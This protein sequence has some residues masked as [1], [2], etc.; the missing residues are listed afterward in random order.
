MAKEKKDVDSLSV[1]VSEPKGGENFGNYFRGE[2]EEDVFHEAVLVKIEKGTKTYKGDE[3]PAWVWIYELLS[4]DYMV[5]DSDGNDV[6]AQVREKTSQKFTGG[7][8]RK[9]KA[10]ERY[11]QL[12]GEEPEPGDNVDLRDLF[13]TKCK[14]MITNTDSGKETDEGDPIIYHNIEKVSI[15]GIK[16]KVEKSSSKKKLTKKSSKKKKKV[17]KEPEEEPEEDEDDDPLEGLGV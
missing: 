7:A 14:L 3:S 13:D 17:E 12:T 11:C 6:R 16:E 5:E 15:K 10:Y 8:S 4:E 9:S 2:I 1:T